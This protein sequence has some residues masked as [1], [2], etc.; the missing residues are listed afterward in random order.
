M[1]LR[2]M[3]ERVNLRQEDV[4]R[5]M[6]VDQGAVSKWENGVT[7]PLRKYRKELARLYGCTVDEL[8]AEES[9]AAPPNSPM[10]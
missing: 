3:R 2:Q 5:L 9:G 7:R 1:T 8:L 4:A 6:N 10:G